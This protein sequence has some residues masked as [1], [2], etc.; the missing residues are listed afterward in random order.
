LT[1]ADILATIE[2][3]REEVNTSF[4]FH[5]QPIQPLTMVR[6]NLLIVSHIRYTYSVGF[7][8]AYTF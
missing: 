7:L 3:V 2:D 4:Y 8:F 5:Q 1:G 6:Y